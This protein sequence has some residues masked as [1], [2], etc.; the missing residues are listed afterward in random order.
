VPPSAHKQER[1]LFEV[2]QIESHFFFVGF[3][4]YI[5]DART[6]S[7]WTAPVRSGQLARDLV[8]IRVDPGGRLR[9]DPVNLHEISCRSGWIRVDGSGQIR[10]RF[11]SFSF[12]YFIASIFFSI[13]SSLFSFLFVFERKKDAPT[14]GGVFWFSLLFL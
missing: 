6:R 7:G 4:A 5:I 8:Q 9:S 1:T 12:F 10:R 13:L 14:F 2:T 3:C 11:L